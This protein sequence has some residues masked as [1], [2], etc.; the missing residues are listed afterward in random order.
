M[1][2]AT[3][4]LAIQARRPSDRR[5]RPARQRGYL[6][7]YRSSSHA[8]KSDDYLVEMVHDEELD[9]ASCVD[10]ESTTGAP[11]KHVVHARSIGYG[12][13]QDFATKNR[14]ISPSEH[15]FEAVGHK[16]EMGIRQEQPPTDCSPAL[17]AIRVD[18]RK[19]RFL[20]LQVR[21]R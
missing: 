15:P 9:T 12:R 4:Q 2:G 1:I 10:L 16:A 11:C 5:S 8:L 21:F 13:R 3:R 6:S 19:D 18:R 20:G 17:S 7:G 14:Q